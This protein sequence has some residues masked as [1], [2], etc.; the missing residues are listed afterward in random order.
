MAQAAKRNMK[1]AVLD[2]KSAYL[3]ARVTEDIYMSVPD[4]VTPPGP[5]LCLKLNKSLYGL[6]QAGR[7][8]HK[9]L[10]KKMTELGMRQSVWMVIGAETP[11]TAA[12]QQGTCT[13]PTADPSAG[14]ARNKPAPHYRRVSPSTWPRRKRPRR[15]CG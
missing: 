8:W 9:L 12:R 3:M 14:E 1:I 15:R 2:I 6:K 13:Y 11:T 4:G 7:C 10:H 5:N